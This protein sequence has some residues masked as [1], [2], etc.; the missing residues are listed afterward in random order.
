MGPRTFLRIGELFDIT[1]R[2]PG[3]LDDVIQ[4]LLKSEKAVKISDFI[5]GTRNRIRFAN[6]ENKRESE[7]RRN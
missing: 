1:E 5:R 2:N 4:E 6:K 7:E 3:I